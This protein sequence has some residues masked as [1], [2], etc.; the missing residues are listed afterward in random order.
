MATRSTI[1]MVTNCGG[2]D[3]IYCHYDGYPEH[4]GKTLYASYADEKRVAKL[5]DMGDVSQLGRTLAKCRF[6]RRDMGR[7]EEDTRKVTH[8][9]L[10]E[11][12]AAMDERRAWLE[13][14][15]LFA[16]GRWMIHALRGDGFYR[17]QDAL[18]VLKPYRDADRGFTCRFCDFDDIMQENGL[19]PRQ[20]NAPSSLL[21]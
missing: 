13:Y 19:R 21:A 8:K 12:V 16:D 15:Y 17:L 3:A 4:V 10:S 5:M 14:L 6:Y 7:A 2:I 11:A 20:F 18:A 9:S 1:A